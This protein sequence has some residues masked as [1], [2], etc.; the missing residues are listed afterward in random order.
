MYRYLKAIGCLPSCQSLSALL[1]TAHLPFTLQQDQGAPL[2]IER[3][4]T[5]V[6]HYAQRLLAKSSRAGLGTAFD[7]DRL[8]ASEGFDP[9]MYELFVCIHLLDLGC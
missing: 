8:L 7:A 1:I 6:E 2:R 5:Q 3:D 9:T 4:L